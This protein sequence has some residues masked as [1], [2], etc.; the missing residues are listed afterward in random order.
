MSFV[1]DD[2]VVTLSPQLD[3]RRLE[4]APAPMLGMIELRYR[5]P[6]GTI[7]SEY[8]DSLEARKLCMLLTEAEQRLDRHEAAYG[9]AAACMAREEGRGV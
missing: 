5:E 6:D 1:P 3:T 7:A 2:Q 8:L 9:H 4:V